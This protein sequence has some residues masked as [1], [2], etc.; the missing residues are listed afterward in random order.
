MIPN[1]IHAGI[2]ALVFALAACSSD[3]PDDRNLDIGETVSDGEDGKEPGLAD[4][5]L[6]D[7]ADYRG[8]IGTSIAATTLPADPMIRA[9]G[10]NDIVTQDYRPHRTNIVYREK[11]GTIFRVYCG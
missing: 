4:I 2:A 1:P 11:G 6:C 3:V 7:A 5:E 9:F 10:E 8:L